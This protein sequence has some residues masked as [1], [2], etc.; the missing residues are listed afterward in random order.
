MLW[1][2]EMLASLSCTSPERTKEIV[3]TQIV[4]DELLGRFARQQHDWFER[5]RKGSLDPEAVMR[6]V[7]ALIDR[8]Y[9][10][11]GEIF[12][13]TLDGSDPAMHPIEMVRRYGYDHPE[14]W[15]FTGTR[16]DRTETRRFKLVEI[17]YQP[18]FDAVLKAL[19]SHGEIAGGQWR[20]AFRAKYQKPDGKGPIGVADPSWMRPFGP[21]RFPYVSTAGR[22]SFHWT[23]DD[24]HDSWRWLV[25]VSK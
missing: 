23:G 20:E 7:Q 4:A 3:M 15:R 18:N 19:K 1:Q 17:G 11:T 8:A 6:A 14:K 21:I 12:E 13:L 9:P 10:A 5:V 24:F 2:S 25:E 22:S 16:L